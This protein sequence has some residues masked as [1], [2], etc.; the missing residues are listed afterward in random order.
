MLDRRLSRRRLIVALAAG[1]TALLAACGGGGATPSAGKPAESQPAAKPTEAPAQGAAATK[2]AAAEKPAAATK[3]AE[4][5]KPTEAP[6]AAAAAPAKGGGKPISFLCRNDIV[7]A[8]GADAIVDEWNK[9]HDAKVTLE[10]PPQGADLAAKA[11]AAIAAD[12]MVWDGFSVIVAPWDIA[13]W[14]KREI[15]V[16]IDDL[17][18]ASSVPDADK[19]FAGMIGTIRESVKE[20]GKTYLIPGNVGSSAL[21]WFWDPLKEVGANQQPETWEETRE[22]AV[23][24]K[25]KSS[26]KTPFASIGTPL[27]DLNSLMYGAIKPDEL[28]TKE[29]VFNL[30]HEGA[31]ASLKWM[32]DMAKD[33]LMPTIATDVN[34]NWDKGTVVMMLAYDVKGQHAQKTYGYDKADTGVNIFRK[35]GDI[36]SGTPFWMNGSVVFNKAK[37]PQGIADFFLWWFGP[38]N[39]AAQKTMVATAAKPCYTYTYEKF[40]K[41]DPKFK[42]EQVGIDLVAKSKPYPTH[43]YFSIEQEALKPWVEKFMAADSTLSAEDALRSAAKDRADKMS[44]QKI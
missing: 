40:V 13:S 19:V 17:I 27:F 2:P 8:Y 9:N 11:Q 44:K 7:T 22:L 4:A 24:V 31:V 34:A 36:A 28:F 33:G 43:T 26:D 21:Q 3:P 42:W 5:A 30:E 32:K 37:N 25:A 15:I 16:P 10:K 1:G 18:K 20:S 6:K 39:D 38:S 29:G 14:A 35:K 23:K 12:D 41:D